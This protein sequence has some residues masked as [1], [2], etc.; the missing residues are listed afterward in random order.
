MSNLLQNVGHVVKSAISGA[1]PEAVR[2]RIRPYR[3]TDIS[4]KQWDQ[5]YAKGKWQYLDNIRQLAH[6]SVIMGYYLYYRPHSNVLDIG[7]GHGVLQRRLSAVGYARYV[8]VDT[9]QHAIDQANGG[10]DGKTEFY[11][12]DAESYIPQETF[13]VLIFNE[14]LYY[15]SA[16]AEALIQLAR[17]VNPGGVV[18]VSM[19]QKE[20]S[21]V[22]WR[23]LDRIA[24]AAD[25]VRVIN[26]D[27]AK[28][29]VKVFPMSNIHG[30]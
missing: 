11:C 7:C 30:H 4:Q 5:D 8:G 14:S 2:A 28:W 1:V 15:F 10:R 20:S 3:K 17:S 12:A 19:Y 6:Y 16:P 24:R 21:R 26:Q 22:I 13:D 25:A 29:D 23:S 9:S 27:R 18:I